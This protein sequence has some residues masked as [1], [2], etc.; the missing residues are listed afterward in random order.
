[1]Q[2]RG[3][4]SINKTLTL[5]FTFESSLCVLRRCT[6]LEPRILFQMEFSVHPVQ[7][8]TFVHEKGVYTFW[9][10]MGPLKQSGFVAVL[11][12]TLYFARRELYTFWAAF[13]Y[14]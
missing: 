3:E 9:P 14:T 8:H 5:K 13:L 11:T 12:N 1:M 10:T 6:W 2:T 4:I 7:K